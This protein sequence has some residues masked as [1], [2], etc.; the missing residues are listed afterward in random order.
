M[1]YAFHSLPLVSSSLSWNERGQR[2][3][4]EIVIIWFFALWN[5]LPNFKIKTSYLLDLLQW[6]AAMTVA[7]K[8]TITICGAELWEPIIKDT[9]DTVRSKRL[10]LLESPGVVYK[11]S[12]LI[13]KSWPYHF[14][15]H[16]NIFNTNLSNKSNSRSDTTGNMKLK[17]QIAKL[18]KLLSQGLI[19]KGTSISSSQI[20][21][22]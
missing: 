21:V 15:P 7:M 17:L 16:N 3:N 19:Y 18:V 10:M 13:I 14:F 12:G 8:I 9:N 20:N 2:N 4:T 22:Q 5:V 11:K 1:Q 6:W